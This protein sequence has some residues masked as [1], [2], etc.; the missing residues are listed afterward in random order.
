MSMSYLAVSD[1]G[2]IISPIRSYFSPRFRVSV[3]FS[4]RPTRTKSSPDHVRAADINYIVAR[5]KKTGEL[6]VSSRAAL[7]SD[8]SAPDLKEALDLVRSAEQSFSQLPASARSA[9]DND[10]KALLAALDKA[11]EPDVH[12]Y[13]V[14][15][16]ILEARPVELP[17]APV[18][19]PVSR[20]SKK[21]APQPDLPLED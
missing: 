7:F 6:P 15:A 9:F 14:Q 3:P 5:Y 4:E 18:E 16:G 21:A 13:L 11:G 1:D 10:P 20:K 8:M 12:A 2:E 17:E 19:P